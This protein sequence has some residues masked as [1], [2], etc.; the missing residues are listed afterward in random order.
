MWRI[1]FT[2]DDL[3][4]TRVA[5][6]L[7]P[8]AETLF[9]LVAIRSAWPV[10]AAMLGWRD[11][12]RR[13]LTPA[14]KPLADL[15]PQRTFGVDLWSLIG[16]APTIEQGLA[17]LQALRPQVIRAELADYTRHSTL[18][19]TTWRL[20]DRNG[21][22]RREL[23]AA[24]QVAYRTLVEPYW[25]RVATHLDAE[26]S[27]WHRHQ[28]DGGMERLFAR[29]GP[30]VR[31]VSPVLHVRSY[32]HVDVHLGGRG[33]TLVPSLFV[34]EM[35][36]LLTDPAPFAPPRLVFPTPLDA[37]S[38]TTLEAG[39]SP[40]A[41][42]RLLGRTRARVLAEIAEGCST[43]ELAHRTRISLGAASHHATVLRQA[44]LVA[45]HRDGPAV[46]HILTPLGMALLEKGWSRRP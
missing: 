22:A 19:A 27:A 18:P 13:S 31:W 37:V 43:T 23:A 9:G 46:R 10:P 33:L 6:S 20:A 11:R 4:R 21:T 12:M 28:L 3:A 42:G 16:E 34:G 30:G 45:T 41:L 39:P 15:A 14:L 5:A 8:L 26:R 29:L 17:A 24:A 40:H 35:P 44:G 32:S 1:H 36:L 38:L 25:R 7:G 2:A